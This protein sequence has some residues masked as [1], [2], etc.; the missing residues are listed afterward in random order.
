M[1]KD[2]AFLFYPNDWL[3]GTMGMSFEEQGAYLS[4]LLM[5]FNRGHMTE[6]MIRHTVGHLWDK[7]KDKFSVDEQGLYYNKRLKVEHEK[8]K[9]YSKSRSNNKK[10]LN[11][12][13]KKE[14]HM[15]SHMEN[16]NINEDET[17]IVLDR[18]VGKGGTWN[19]RPGPEFL[20]MD[21]DEVK[22]GAVKILFKATKNHFLTNDQLKSLWQV[23]KAQHFTGEKFYQSPNDVYSHFINWSKTQNINGT[24]QQLPT[25]GSK[26]GTSDAR[27][28]K[29]SEW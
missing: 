19:V 26:L 17:V 8:R 3:G 23:F 25:N 5:Q 7:I 27:I 14:G 28:K 20:E 9:T 22:A 2:P 29:A 4:L 18:G 16:A 21:L 24:H 10:G 12:Y 6:H 1:A 13:T 11:Q 15:T